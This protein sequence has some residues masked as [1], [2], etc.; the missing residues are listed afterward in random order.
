MQKARKFVRKQGLPGLVLH[1]T[2]GEEPGQFLALYHH[3]QSQ[4]VFQNGMETR[5]KARR[6]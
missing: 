2:S 1:L 3:R 5:S 6:L 4:S